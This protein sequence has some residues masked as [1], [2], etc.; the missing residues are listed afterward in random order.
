MKISRR[1]FCVAYNTEENSH[2]YLL[3]AVLQ[4]MNETWT[5]VEI[6]KFPS[7]THYHIYVLWTGNVEILRHVQS[8]FLSVW[9]S[10]VSSRP[11]FKND[12]IN[13]SFK[14]IL[15]SYYTSGASTTCNAVAPPITPGGLKY[16]RNTWEFLKPLIACCYI[17]GFVY[18]FL[19]FWSK[20]GQFLIIVDTTVFWFVPSPTCGSWL[21]QSLNSVLRIGVLVGL[22]FNSLWYA[23]CFCSVYS[24]NPTAVF[25]SVIPFIW[26]KVK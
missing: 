20:F 19:F 4:Y 18:V 24:S 10:D 15:N 23:S 16:K 8:V 17:C 25:V 22:I 11:G 2:R 12:S 9:L 5:W 7:K 14:K 21:Y 26:V 13:N 1:T 3:W 6:S